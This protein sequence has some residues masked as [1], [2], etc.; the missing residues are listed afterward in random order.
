MCCALLTHNVDSML[1]DD[2]RS[3][4]TCRLSRSGWFLLRVAYRQSDGADNCQLSPILL[5]TNVFQR[6][7]AS[8]IQEKSE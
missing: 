1:E 5:A 3:R 8:R 7:G 4:D 6:V 2:L